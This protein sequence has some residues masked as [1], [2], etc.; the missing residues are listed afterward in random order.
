MS[1]SAA[2]LHTGQLAGALEDARRCVGLHPTWPKGHG[3]VGAALHA[4]GRLHAA[5]EAYSLG[6]RLDPCSPALIAGFDCTAAAVA[7]EAPAR[8]APPSAPLH[9]T[10]AQPVTVSVVGTAKAGKSTVLNSLLGASF[11]PSGTLCETVAVVEIRHSADPA[12]VGGVLSTVACCPRFARALRSGRD[13]AGGGPAVEL[14]RGVEAINAAIRAVN[15]ELREAA[16]LHSGRGAPWLRPG[17]G[18]RDVHVL[19]SG[20]C[21]PVRPPQLLLQLPFPRALGPALLGVGPGARPLGFLDTPGPNEA[22]P[23]MRR[24]VEANAMGAM[25]AADAVLV[26]LNYTTMGTSDEQELLR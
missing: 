4:L 6:L 26:V 2:R 7:R 3:R 23:G 12:H 14:A 5:L 24:L 19:A 10:T 16:T 18:D 22:A 21:L 8:A 1:R 13:L 15:K 9:T 20:L 25:Q 17:L 11:L